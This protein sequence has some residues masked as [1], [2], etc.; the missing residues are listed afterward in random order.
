MYRVFLKVFYDGTGYYGS[1]RQPGLR[2]VEGELLEAFN[3]IQVNPVELN[4]SGRTDRGVHSIG[5]TV[6]ITL[7]RE[8]DEEKLVLRLNEELPHDIAVW[9][10]RMV[11]FEWHPRYSSVRRSYIYVDKNAHVEGLNKVMRIFEGTHNFS[12]FS[13]VGR[14]QDPWRRIISVKVYQAGEFTLYEFHGDAFLR[15]MVRRLITVSKLIASGRIGRE[16]VLRALEG[17]ECGRLKAVKPAAPWRLIL[18][19]VWYPFSFVKHDEGLAKALDYLK[20]V[21]MGGLS[22]LIYQVF[23]SR[24]YGLL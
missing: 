13:I 16:E 14:W 2:T 24:L 7:R 17:G 11:N 12:C 15:Q 20:R 9:G 19:N 4:F 10:F 3:R 21:R 6:A 5:Q 18:L 22:G 1:Q 8:V 23:S